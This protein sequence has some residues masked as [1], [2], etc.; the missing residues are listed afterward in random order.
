[1]ILAHGTLYPNDA[2]PRLRD[3]LAQECAETIA[4]QTVDAECVIAACDTLARRAQQGAYD[5]AL[6][7]FLREAQ[8]PRERL[9]EALA[10][11]RRESLTYKAA[12]EWG[13]DAQPQPLRR[14][15]GTEIRRVRRP[16]GVLLHIAAGNVDGL[17]AYS[18]VEGLLAGNVNLLKLPSADRGASILLLQELVTIE[19]RLRDF[20]YV[21]DVPSSD[22]DS[23][24]AFARVADGV[25]VWGGDEAVRAARGL[26]PPDTKIIAW[27][28]KL[29]FAYAEPDA[30]DEALRALARHVC[31]TRQLLCSSCQGIFCDTEDM[32]TVNALAERFFALLQEENAR[33]QPAPLPLRA[34]AAL[35]MYCAQLEAHADGRRVLRADGVGVLVARDSRLEL[36]PLA[37]NCWVKPLPRS[38]IVAEL[39]PYKG[40]LQT[41]GLLCAD[42]LRPTLCEALTRA[43]AVRITRAHDM[44]RALA[45]E[46]HD[47]AY[48]LREYTRIVEWE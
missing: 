20:V 19:P 6:L 28:H 3:A 15:D 40:Y 41:V 8:I 36:S 13:A 32:A 17:P 25:V 5:A 16:L 9:A 4:A 26:V 1:M 43:G 35:Q 31:E 21:F 48:P 45:G 47:G 12:V 7:P 34:K 30:P 18:V 33:R 27:G 46:A 37:G 24:A 29:S 10:L 23:L 42:A 2:L 44:S 38:R 22:L 11:L 14:P 39:K